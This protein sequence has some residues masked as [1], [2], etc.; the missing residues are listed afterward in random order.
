MKCHFTI[1][2][3]TLLVLAVVFFPGALTGRLHTAFAQ[4]K[5]AAQAQTLEAE[6]EYS[7]DEY[8][9]YDSAAKEPD[10]LKRGTM[11]VDFV[12]KYPKSKLMSYIDAA[13]KSLLFECAN[14]KKFPELETL[15]EQW[16]KSHPNDM[17]TIA[18]VA[19]ATEKL[20]HYDR[21]VQCLEQLYA[22]QPTGSMAYNIAQTYKR[23]NK[24]DKFL[25]WTQTVFKY[26]D[27]DGDYKLR[28]D[29]VQ[30]FVGVKDFAKAA[31]Y[32]QAT[33]KSADLVKQPSA[34][35][36][37]QLRAV[38]RACYHIIGVNLFE[39]DKFAEALTAFQRALRAER[40][41]EGYYYVALCLRKQDKID[42]AMLWYAKAE[43][44]GGEVAPKAK[45]NLEQVYKALHNNTLIGI[46]KIYKKAKEQPESYW[47]QNI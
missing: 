25:Q 41:G 16:L 2:F 32:A 15:A 11:L 24:G 7:E 29:L 5:P 28:Y 39:K 9:A 34:E 20:G 42:D 21:C 23:L 3:L 44:E 12:Q 18:Y 26:S 43:L 19:D 46:E 22:M 27:F 38:R 17:Q 8:N 45:Q 31:E 35:T 13:Y 14:N 1:A 47:L 6:P 33:L 10:F 37:E 40:Y 4:Q 30:W 36:Q